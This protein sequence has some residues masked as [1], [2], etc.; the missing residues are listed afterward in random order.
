MLG[1]A[2]KIKLTFMKVLI[3]ILIGYACKASSQYVMLPYL[4]DKLVSANGG[5][6]LKLSERHGIERARGRSLMYR[7][8]TV[9]I[10]GSVREIGYFYITI[11]LG[12]P[13]RNFSLIIDT[14]S[15][16]SYVPCK[17]CKH[18]GQ[19]KDDAFDISASKTAVELNCK[20]TLCNCGSPPCQ[21]V[22]DK[23]YYKRTYAEQS[24]SAGFLVEDRFQFPDSKGDVKLV[25]GCESDETGEIFRQMA[26]GI[27]GMGNNN[28]AFQS[29]LVEQKVIDD[30]FG[31][32]FGYPQGGTM[33][34]GDVRLKDHDKMQYTNLTKGQQVHYYTVLMQGM[35]IDDNLLDVDPAAYSVGY[36]AVVDSGT[37]FT[38]LPTAAFKQFSA[39]VDKFAKSKGLKQAKGEDPQYNDICWSGAPDDMFKLDAYFPKATFVFKP[40]VHIEMKPLQYL[41]RMGK[42]TFCLGIFDNQASGTLIG[43][44]SVRN[45]LVQYDRR[46]KRVGFLS[47]DCNHLTITPQ[48]EAVPSPADEAGKSSSPQAHQPERTADKSEESLQS[49]AI[50]KP[51]A[52]GDSPS[53]IKDGKGQSVHPA[54][55]KSP[56]VAHSSTENSPT[57]ASS[58][59]GASKDLGHGNESSSSAPLD[60]SEDVPNV[61]K[62]DE[63]YVG[64]DYYAAINGGVSEGITLTP[65]VT[66]IA[67]IALVVGSGQLVFTYRARIWDFLL[68]G[69]RRY[70]S[71]PMTEEP[72]P[73]VMLTEQ[74]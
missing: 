55:L 9:P 62:M 71:V 31:L 33:L 67:L 27:L 14:G 4:S 69:F 70:Q 24:S 18:C 58:P 30:T 5:L 72:A 15:T 56:S 48:A 49:P 20:S 16:I 54:P 26:D 3:V 53:S 45:V 63:D 64:E 47:V 61:K 2:E 52:Q 37:T 17:G 13:R 21:C 40:D 50:A 29:Q 74:R 41:F 22:G 57:S 32:C 36:G 34:L 7:S 60:A 19:H 43:G 25:F 38:Y 59:Q 51:M 1:A 11:S 44:I 73:T 10:E 8:G 28:N 6:V 46:N 39:A 68:H 42:G 23:C 35:Q 66:A 12:T 65:L